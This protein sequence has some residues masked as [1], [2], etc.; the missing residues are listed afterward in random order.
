MARPNGARRPVPFPF[1]ISISLAALVALTLWLA[2]SRE[3]NAAHGAG[4][5]LV[6]VNLV[7]FGYYGFDKHRAR[8]LASRVPET[9]LHGLTVLGGSGGALAGMRT[10]RHKT[11]KAGF[12]VLFWLIVAAQ[13]GLALSIAWLVWKS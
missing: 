2:L 3:A 13:A 8:G 9:V 6:A 7:A 5:W 12:R 11:L 1:A 10:F 4:C